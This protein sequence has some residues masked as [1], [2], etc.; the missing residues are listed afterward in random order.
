MKHFNWTNIRL[1]LMFGAILFMFSFTAKRNN[2]RKLTKTKIV[3]VGDNA[4]F[5]N[6]AAV[7]K[8]LIENHSNVKSMSK[9]DIDLNKLEKTLNAHA[10]IEKSELFLSI[11]GAM[12]AIVKQKTPVARILDK[13]ESY[14]IDYKGSNM[15]LSQN[16]TAR[17]PLVS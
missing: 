15:P 3:F 10:M 13:V 6:Q 17:V 14:Y 2:L 4:P 12:T 16:Y 8:L 7:N 11:D 9:H 1:V 5:I